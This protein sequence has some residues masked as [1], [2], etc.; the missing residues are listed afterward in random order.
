MVVGGV[1]PSLEEANK[2]LLHPS[3]GGKMY[4]NLCWKGKNKERAGTEAS[5]G[6]AK[7][8]RERRPRDRKRNVRLAICQTKLTFS[9]IH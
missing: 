2:F 4:G 9:N 7:Q 6:E 1:E 3:L 8:T 5:E